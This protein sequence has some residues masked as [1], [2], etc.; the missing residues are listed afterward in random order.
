MF[1]R[2][3]A[4][5]LTCLALSG[6]APASLHAQERVYKVPLGALGHCPPTMCYNHLPMRWCYLTKPPLV[7]RR[8]AGRPY[9][10]LD[11]AKSGAL[12]GCDKHA[13]GQ[14]NSRCG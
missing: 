2:L 9:C 6:L 13:P 12:A 14:Q 10:T 7:P 8:L 1:I 4:L 5:V 3:L 11:E